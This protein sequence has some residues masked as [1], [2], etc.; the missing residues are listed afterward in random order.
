VD[1]SKYNLD[2]VIR[3]I[4]FADSKAQFLLAIT[5][6]LFGASFAAVPSGARLAV[7]WVKAGGALS[8]AAGALILL[9]ASFF[10]FAVLTILKLVHVVRPRLVPKTCRKS[11]LFYQ[12][13]SL[14]ELAEFKRAMANMND[15]QALDE[16]AD[17]TYNNASVAT[18]KY[19][20]V[21]AATKLL[22][23]AGTLGIFLV[24]VVSL[25][26]IQSPAGG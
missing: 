6:A 16:L 26:G 9:Y 10:V 19:R 22:L 4:H 12:T 3:W 25:F 13:A 15:A 1:I 14:M 23:V 24:L 7:A 21:Q 2:L 18:E 5:L 20:D 8:L 11:P 17:Q